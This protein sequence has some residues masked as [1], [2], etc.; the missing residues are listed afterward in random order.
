VR[1]RRGAVAQAEVVRRAGVIHDRLA[2]EVFEV[3]AHP[4]RLRPVRALRLMS[5]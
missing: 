4:L 3:I 2:V 5:G 1:F